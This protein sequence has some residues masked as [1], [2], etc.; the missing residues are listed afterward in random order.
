LATTESQYK[1]EYAS[2]EPPE[3]FDWTLCTCDLNKKYKALV[4]EIG[5]EDIEHRGSK[6]LETIHK[7]LENPGVLGCKRLQPEVIYALL[8]QFY[9]MFKCRNLTIFITP[10]IVFFCNILKIFRAFNE[11]HKF[12]RLETTQVYDLDKNLFICCQKKV[13]HISACV[14]FS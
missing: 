5:D 1:F 8:L 2:H 6:R 13:V 7:I 3:E 4:D 12:W 10:K 14:I 9:V 11:Q